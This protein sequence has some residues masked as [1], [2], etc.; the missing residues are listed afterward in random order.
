MTNVIKL[1][2][3]AQLVNYNWAFCLRSFIF[4]RNAIVIN[5]EKS[6]HFMPSAKD[7]RSKLLNAIKFIEDKKHVF[8]HH[9]KTD[10]FRKR[11]LSITN[12][13]TFLLGMQEKSLAGELLDFDNSSLQGITSSA[14]IQARYKL[15]LS[16]FEHVFH[17]S[18]VNSYETSQYQGYRLLAQDGSD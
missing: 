17:A 15:K 13:F 5:Y 16:A 10:F 9:P 8:V 14:M 4:L 2:Q 7:L 6:V 1:S 11:T 18:H 12:I 3:K